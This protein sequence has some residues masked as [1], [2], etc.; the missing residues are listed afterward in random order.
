MLV[1]IPFYKI[2]YFKSP[3]P[4]YLYKGVKYEYTIFQASCKFESPWF[5]HMRISRVP[6]RGDLIMYPCDY[7]ANRPG[8]CNGYGPR[9]TI[10]GFFSI[11]VQQHCHAIGDHPRDKTYVVSR[12]ILYWL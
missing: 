6:I 7:K 1:H 2:Y 9:I 10:F 4:T 11:P 3:G 12:Y 8:F 5:M